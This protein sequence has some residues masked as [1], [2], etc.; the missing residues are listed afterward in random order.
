[1]KKLSLLALLI[2]MVSCGDE[3]LYVAPDGQDLQAVLIEEIPDS[4]ASS[5]DLYMAVEDMPEFPGGQ[6]AYN[7]YL[8]SNL[9]YPK[10]ARDLGVEGNVFLSFTVNTDGSLSDFELLRGIG[11]GCDEEALRVYMESPDWTP[12]KQ[13]G[14]AVKTKVQAKVAF[15]L[16]GGGRSAAPEIEEIVEIPVSKTVNVHAIKQN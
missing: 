9:K 16:S 2:F 12:G 14:V 6:K 15:K 5:S 8:L 13:R 10:Q 11:G 4:E 3:D 7:K 1:M